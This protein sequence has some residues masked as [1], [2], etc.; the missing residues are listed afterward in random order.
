MRSSETLTFAAQS[1]RLDVSGWSSRHGTFMEVKQGD[2]FPALPYGAQEPS[3]CFA[4]IMVQQSIAPLLPFY[5][6][7]L[8]I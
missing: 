4:L 7:R 2:R 8:L 1:C 6:T 3:R 5:S